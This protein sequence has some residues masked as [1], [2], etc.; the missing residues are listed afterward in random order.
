MAKKKSSTTVTAEVVTD[1]STSNSKALN[2]KVN[3]KCKNHKQKELVK[4]I[5][6]SSITFVKGVFGVGKTFVINSVALEMLKNPESGIKKITL[7]VPTV[8]TGAMH[9]G[10]LPG[11]LNQKLENHVINELDAMRKI[12]DKSGNLKA[13]TIIDNLIKQ[14]LIDI[15]PI[16]Y[17]RGASL[18]NTFICVSEAEEF[19]KEELFLIISRFESGKMVISGD[20]L[21]A[22]RSI[23]RNGNSG[24]LHAMDRL[25]DINGVGIV[26]FTDEDIVRNDILFDIYQKWKN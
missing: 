19:T 12:L 21:Q 6:A 17:L 16:S 13:N 20:P 8:E 1:A 14:E 26:E 15:R 5:E 9:L 4:T 22:S 11:D 24:L 3:L 25:K 18:E 23:V 7:I 2:Y 10:L